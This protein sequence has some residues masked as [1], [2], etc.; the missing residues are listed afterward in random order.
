M[1]L[2]YQNFLLIK[3]CLILFKFQ[4]IFYCLNFKLLIKNCIINSKYHHIN[5]KFGLLIIYKMSN[6]FKFYLVLSISFHLGTL[7]HLIPS[8]LKFQ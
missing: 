5:K 8:Q 1:L 3:N 4:V 7:N 2:Q 6:T